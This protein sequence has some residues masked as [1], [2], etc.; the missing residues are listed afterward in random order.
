ML[1]KNNKEKNTTKII[2]HKHLFQKK[3]NKIEIYMDYD[4]A[5]NKLSGK[6]K[7]KNYQKKKKKKY[8]GTH[9]TQANLFYKFL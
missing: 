1:T 7:N 8:D 9:F 2:R 6:I 5:N 4:H 3:R